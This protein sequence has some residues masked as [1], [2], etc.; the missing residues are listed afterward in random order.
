MPRPEEIQSEIEK[1]VAL[2]VEEAPV[3]DLVNLF[4]EYAYLTKASDVHLHP[5]H[6]GMRARYRIDGI[7]RDM[8][9][10]RIG[11]ELHEEVI[12]RIKVMAGLR[13]DEHLAPQDGRFKAQLET[14]DE[15]DVRVSILPTYY[16]E[17]AVL[18][19]LAETQGFALEDLGFYKEGL[20]SVYR[21]IALSHQKAQC[22][23]A[24]GTTFRWSL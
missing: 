18:R 4:V 20:E 11:H 5:E 12:T 14:K 10:K 2:P 19:V 1:I 23:E 13:T 6:D 3:I 21:A 7:L 17:N 24:H 9:L 22:A 8:L 16:G 15:V